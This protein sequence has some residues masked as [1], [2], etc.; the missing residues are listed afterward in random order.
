MFGNA[1]TVVSFAKMIVKT[2]PIKNLFSANIAAKRQSVNIQI[3][4]QP[5]QQAEKASLLN[6]IIIF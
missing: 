2:L 6:L 1:P 5:L 3:D 4:N